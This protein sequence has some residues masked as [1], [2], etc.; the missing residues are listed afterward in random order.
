MSSSSNQS[1]AEL[2]V[3]LRDFT[4]GKADEDGELLPYVLSE[5][6]VIARCFL[7]G[8]PHSLPP[9]ALVNEAYLKMFAGG[10]LEIRDRSHFFATASQA[11]RQVLV[12]HER[13]KARIKRGG[14]QQRVNLVDELVAA[15]A[16]EGH[17]MVELDQAL[18]GL[19]KRDPQQAR[20]V[21]LRF[22]GG[23]EVAE[24]ADVL[25]MSKSGVER[26][27]RE[28]REWLGQAIQAPH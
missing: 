7:R 11:I 23:L 20:I 16:G 27:W 14:H 24:V 13:N 12:D 1:P 5:L 19:A 10:K 2:T 18:T 21:E 8:Q 15:P 4:E 6:D 17:D 25:E 22:F 3:F 28:A 9:M 26:A